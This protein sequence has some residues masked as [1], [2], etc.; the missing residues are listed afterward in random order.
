MKLQS[1]I[2]AAALTGVMFSSCSNDSKL[3][4]L[5]KENEMDYPIEIT[6]QFVM[7]SA[8]DDGEYVT[9][10]YI[11][12]DSLY[13]PQSNTK[14]YGEE[15]VKTISLQALRDNE[16][17]RPFFDAVVEAK[18]GLK[19]VYIGTPSGDSCAIV[20]SPEEV[21]AAAESSKQIAD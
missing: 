18:R 3:K 7:E 12:A 1:I 20:I 13:D 9:Y 15:R 19:Y 11:Y 6:N 4:A 14:R 2:I 5:L 10:R 17:S 8:K 16:S 21:A